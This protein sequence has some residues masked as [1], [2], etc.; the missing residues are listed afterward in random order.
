MSGDAAAAG[1]LLIGSML[2]LAAVG[3]GIGSFVGLAVPGG[4]VGLFIGVF[5]GLGL[6]YARFRTL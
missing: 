1:F 3:Y 2:L 5:A 6:V 4:V